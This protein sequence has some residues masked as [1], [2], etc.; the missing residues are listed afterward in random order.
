MAALLCD[1][2]A[3]QHF[4]MAIPLLDVWHLEK[5]LAAALG[6]CAAQQSL[7]PLMVLAL[8]EHWAA[9]TEDDER[10]QHLALLLEYIDA[11]ATA[12]PATRAGAPRPPARSRRSWTWSSA[13]ASRPRAPLGTAPAPIASSTFV[14]SRRTRA[15]NATGLPAALATSIIAALAA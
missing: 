15:G 6:D 5:R 14:S 1:T 8:A 3:N 7:A 4:P 11:I 13:A 9:A 12:S 10:R 2:C